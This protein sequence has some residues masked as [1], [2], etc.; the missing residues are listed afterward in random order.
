[1]KGGE[2]DQTTWTIS[3]TYN[4]PERSGDVDERYYIHKLGA[5]RGKESCIKRFTPETAGAD[6]GQLA[7]SSAGYDSKCKGCSVRLRA[8]KEDKQ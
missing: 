1:M 6:C 8:A 4:L 7:L 3:T 2:G 5:D